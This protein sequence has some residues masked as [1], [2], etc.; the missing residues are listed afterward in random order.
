MSFRD[1]SRRSGA[2]RTTP[3]KRQLSDRNS[4]GG[5]SVGR[6]HQLT[7][8]NSLHSS[9][10]ASSSYSNIQNAELPYRYCTDTDNSRDEQQLDLSQQREED[11]AIQLMREREQELQDINHKM[12]VVNEIYKDL[13]EVVDQQ[14]E[15]IDTIEDQ[16]G[17]ASDN[18]R[19]GL[20][21]LEKANAKGKKSSNA[22]QDETGEGETQQDECQFVLLKYVQNKMSSIGKMVSVCGGSASASYSLGEDDR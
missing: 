9:A 3:P 2:N 11:Y 22:K 20:E 12:H 7:I 6:T 15:Q 17:R 5:S 13:G 19:R 14:Q 21:Q 16:F 18:A 10:G 4:S 1:I 8:K